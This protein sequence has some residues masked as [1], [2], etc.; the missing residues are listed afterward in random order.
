MFWK[1]IL[2]ANTGAGGVGDKTA[3]VASNSFLKAI[4][5]SNEIS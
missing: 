1:L 5:D 4:K 2:T 3:I